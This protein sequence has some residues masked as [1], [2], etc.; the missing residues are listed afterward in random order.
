M[1][2]LFRKR[3]RAL[4]V[5]ESEHLSNVRHH[6]K[7]T[8]GE[9]L[10]RRESTVKMCAT[11]QFVE[12]QQALHW[13]EGSTGIMHVCAINYQFATGPRVGNIA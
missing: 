6:L 11:K 1:R 13:D 7:P 2:N 12:I 5:F 10:E 8:D 9:H 3:G 4:T